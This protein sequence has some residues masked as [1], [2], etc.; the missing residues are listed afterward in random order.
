MP[1]GSA[2]PARR[3]GVGSVVVTPDWPGKTREVFGGPV[4]PGS[5]G[6]LSAG[7][8][9][10]RVTVTVSPCVDAEDRAGDLQ[11]RGGG[12]VAPHVDAVAVGRLDPSVP[13]GEV[14]AGPGRADDVPGHRSRDNARGGGTGRRGERTEGERDDAEQE[15]HPGCGRPSHRS[16]SAP[17]GAAAGCP[18]TPAPRSPGRRGPGHRGSRS[19]TSSDSRRGSGCSSRRRR[20]ARAPRW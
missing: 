1:P 20:S 2:S 8:L 15:E 19:C 9:L 3:P 4:G 16:R 10:V 12:G 14:E 5:V 13:R 11:A 7:R 17:S 18:G 6:V